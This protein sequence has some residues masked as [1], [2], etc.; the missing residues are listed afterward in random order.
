MRIS[1]KTTHRELA[2]RR[3]GEEQ[4]RA[5]RQTTNAVSSLPFAG[6]DQRSAS[7][8]S[9]PNAGWDSAAQWIL[10]LR[11]GDGYHPAPLNPMP[12][13]GEPI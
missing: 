3:L 6:Y 2:N 1:L 4:W 10:G 11:I 8:A 13:L 7:L 12:C 9:W 5:Y